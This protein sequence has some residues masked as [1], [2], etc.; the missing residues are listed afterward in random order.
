MGS[1]EKPAEL[2][3]LSRALCPPVLLKRDLSL[4]RPTEETCAGSQCEVQMPKPYSLAS[5]DETTGFHPFP[6]SWSIKII[7]PAKQRNSSIT[8]AHKLDTTL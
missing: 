2:K 1:L 3:A 5:E 6:H 4:M 8:E 7:K